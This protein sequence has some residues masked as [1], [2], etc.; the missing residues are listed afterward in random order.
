MYRQPRVVLH[1]ERAAAPGELRG[2]GGGAG[3]AVGLGRGQ[4]RQGAVTGLEEGEGRLSGGVLFVDRQTGAEAVW[5]Q[6][7]GGCSIEC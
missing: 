2:A 7:L 6:T 3:V 5:Q 4:R 1:H